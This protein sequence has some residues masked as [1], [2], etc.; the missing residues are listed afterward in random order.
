VFDQPM[1]LFS[2]VKGL[3]AALH[4]D[5]AGYRKSG[6]LRDKQQKQIFKTRRF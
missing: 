5:F 2:I 1:E 3:W 6:F 4:G